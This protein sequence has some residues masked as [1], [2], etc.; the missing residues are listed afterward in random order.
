MIF[1]MTRRSS[2]GGSGPSASDAILTVTAPTGSTVTATKGGVTLTPTMWVQAADATLDCALFVISPSLF[3]SQNPWTVTATL[4]QDTAV[5]TVTISE[6]KQ[7]DVFLSFNVYL[8]RNGVLQS[9]YSLERGSLGE[10][11]QASGYVFAKGNSKNVAGVGTIHISVYSVNYFVLEVNEGTV[12]SSQYGT[13]N[14]GFASS[15]ITSL[16][17]TWIAK[18]AFGNEVIPAGTVKQWTMNVSSLDLSNAYVAINL[19]YSHY[20]H[21]VNL[22]FSKNTP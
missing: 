8:V 20:L 3:D 17:Q 6:N 10:F 2:G 15:A 1:D 7:Y 16:G 14:Y 11:R 12:N 18:A 13:D 5:D 21:I 4:V 22:Y 9:G 19:G